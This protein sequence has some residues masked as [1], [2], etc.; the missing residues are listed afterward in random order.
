MDITHYAINFA[1]RNAVS[2][3][4][5]ADLQQVCTLQLMA[6]KSFDVCP[7]FILYTESSMQC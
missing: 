7:R 5:P 6:V 1:G 2:V 4:V 3:A